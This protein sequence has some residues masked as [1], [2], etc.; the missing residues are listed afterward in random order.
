MRIHPSYVINN[1]TKLRSFTDV[2]CYPIFYVNEDDDLLCPECATVTLTDE[3]LSQIV[4]ADVNWE[5]PAM[6]CAECGARIESA[7]A[8]DEDYKP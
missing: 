7:Y 2:G 8:E 1:G 3:D 6:F 5:D 4:S